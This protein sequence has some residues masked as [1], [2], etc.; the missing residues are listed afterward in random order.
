M[1]STDG[2]GEVS[3]IAKVLIVE[4]KHGGSTLTR[5]EV[6]QPEEYVEILRTGNHV[7]PSTKFDVFVLGRKLAASGVGE[8]SLKEP[9]NAVIRPMAYDVL[10]KRAHARTFNLL[11]RVRRSFPEA[12]P[13]ADVEAAVSDKRSL[14]DRD[15]PRVESAS[16]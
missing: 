9:L 6:A 12:K 15:A 4:L 11:E 2:D 13:D 3:G 14:F 1:I 7:Q 16:T 8:R 5:Q 10:L